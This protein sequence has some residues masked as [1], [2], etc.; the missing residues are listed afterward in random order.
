[1]RRIGIAIGG[2]FAV[3]KGLALA[4]VALLMVLGFRA[5]RG[6]AEDERTETGALASAQ[7]LAPPVEVVTASA[8]ATRAPTPVVPETPPVVVEHGTLTLAIAWPDGSP[9]E[10]VSAR[11]WPDADGE[12]LRSHRVA[13]TDASG[14]ASF[15]GLAP[16]AWRVQLDRVKTVERAEVRAGETTTLA[17]A[18]RG[19]TRLEGIV[20]D[21]DG[22]PVAGAGV[23]ISTRG[24]GTSDPLD[25]AFAARTGADGRFAVRAIGDATTVGARAD[26]YAPSRDEKIRWKRAVEEVVLVLHGP[27]GAIDGRVVGPEGEP[28]EGVLVHGDIGL[29]YSEWTSP[30][31]NSSSRHIYNHLAVQVRTD[32]VGAFRFSGVQPGSVE[33]AADHRALGRTSGTVEVVAGQTAALTLEFEIKDAVR[34]RILAVDGAPVAGALVYARRSARDTPVRDDAPWLSQSWK[35]ILA[36]NREDYELTQTAVDGSYRF[37][38]LEAGWTFIAAERDDLGRAFR[39]HLVEPGVVGEIDLVLARGLEL[40]CVVL[41]ER[42]TPQQGL[43]VFAAREMNDSGGTS[44]SRGP[45]ETDTEGRVV[46]AECQAATYQLDVRLPGDGRAL[47]RGLRAGAAE[48]RIVVEH[49]E[50]AT[51]RATGRVLDDSGR[52]L[53][54]AQVYRVRVEGGSGRIA[55]SDEHGRF[56]SEPFEAGACRFW[57]HSPEHPKLELPAR[58]VTD[59]EI[60]DLGTLQ[61]TT[62]GYLDVELRRADGERLDCERMSAGVYRSDGSYVYTIFEI[63]LGHARSD[64]LAAGEYELRVEGDGVSGR[65]PV[66]VEA[67]VTTE[68]E[69]VLRPSE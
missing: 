43:S 35:R 63:E 17:L 66:R 50:L 51:A 64:P 21:P 13:T 60:H 27:G 46:I 28:I 19:D 57:V 23:W 9:A 56:L 42:G 59:G 3:K 44:G 2:G 58:T 26:G 39:P 34:G 29:R 62:P 32:A 15:D 45:F 33:L 37:T 5:T 11:V 24:T 69:L 38:C 8:D 49:R 41:D 55:T 53:P 14:H 47:F 68:L 6:K 20:V 22:R 67:G 16:G 31:G 48:H 18:I 61:L 7:V 52:P 36:G 54:G 30:D 1:V 40:R 4:L 25:D 10:G 65:T 12:F